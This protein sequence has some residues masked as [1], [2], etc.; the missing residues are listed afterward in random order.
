[1]KDEL[2]NVISGKGQVRHGLLIQTITGYLR[3]G[4]EPGQRIAES[5]RLKVQETER[6][7]AYISQHN[8]WINDLD[9][10]KYI[11]Q[12]AEQRV[13]LHDGKHVVKLNDAI[14]YDCWVDYFNNLLLHNYFFPDTAYELVGFTEDYNKDLEKQILYA[15]VKQPFVSVNSATDLAEVRNFLEANGFIN[16]RRN[17]YFN[18]D[19]GII[20]EDLHDENVLTYNGVLYFIDTV[21]YLTPEFRQ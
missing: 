15:V 8:L 6:L 12:G 7:T 5:E 13:Y 4:E 3:K 17:D 10:S 2:L 20:L 1:M 14:Y 9:F 21:F 18:P 11:S 19:L 16:S